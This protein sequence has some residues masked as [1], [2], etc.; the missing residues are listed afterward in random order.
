MFETRHEILSQFNSPVF[1]PHKKFPGMETFSGLADWTG[2][3]TVMVELPKM[4]I[5]IHSLDY[6]RNPH[7]PSD[8]NERQA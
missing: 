2:N 3:N 1:V 5:E 7:M 6:L 8:K 4:K